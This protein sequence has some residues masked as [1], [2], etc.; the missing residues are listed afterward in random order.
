LKILIIGINYAPEVVGIGKYTS[1][2]AEWL[3]GRGHSIRVITAPPYYP[4]WEIAAGYSGAR[5]QVERHGDIRVIRCP[6]WVPRKLDALR[7]ILHLASFALSSFPVLIQQAF[8]FRPDL[9]LV[10]QPP[11]LCA[12]GAWLAACLCRAR[13]WMHIQD[14]EIDAAFEVGLLKHSGIERALRRFETFWMKRFDNISCISQRMIKHLGSKG[15]PAERRVLF[16][17]WVDTQVIRPL[18]SPNSLRKEWG[19]SENDCVA[20][21]AGNMGRKQGLDTLLE[22]ARILEPQSDIHLILA[23]DGS[24]R[25]ILLKQAEGRT[26]V[27]FYPLQPPERLNELLNLADIHLLL[28]R[29]TSSDF[30]MPSKLL[31]ML[32][33][34]RPVIATFVHDSEV[35][36]SLEGCGLLVPPGDGT[37]LAEA[38]LSLARDPI[39][40]QT[41]GRTGRSRALALW[42]KHR[43]LSAFEANLRKPILYV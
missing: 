30:F 19:I 11:F 17:N 33:S 36:R 18:D 14:Y 4:Q 6:L 27:H 2:M 39:R 32:S 22:A 35:A 16:C 37:A 29:S 42:D 9:I 38:I 3:G 8:V 13:L 31:G 40:R 21:Y 26:N 15:I 25:R 1:E 24:M 23:G 20:I 12:P 34:G 7:R 5:Y 28:Q 41:L 10:I 43:V